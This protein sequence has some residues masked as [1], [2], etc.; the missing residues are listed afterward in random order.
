MEAA[1]WDRLVSKRD[2]TEE[3]WNSIEQ[4]FKNGSQFRYR[5]YDYLVVDVM[6]SVSSDSSPI[7]ALKLVERGK[8]V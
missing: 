5:R 4:A 7:A 8:L 2:V 3:V 6:R 1:N